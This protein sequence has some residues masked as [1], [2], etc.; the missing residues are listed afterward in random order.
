M[1]VTRFVTL[2]PQFVLLFHSIYALSGIYNACLLFHLWQIA[3]TPKEQVGTESSL[4]GTAGLD[5]KGEI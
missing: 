2:T 4:Q 3:T 5:V 1:M